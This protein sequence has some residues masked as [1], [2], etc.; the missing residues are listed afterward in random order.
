MLRHKEA[1]V[2]ARDVLHDQE[3]LA[4]IFSIIDGGDDAGV[5]ELRQQP[6]LALEAR[7]Q[8]F[9]VGKGREK[10]L[11]ATVRWSRTCVAR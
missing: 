7:S 10:E 11:H 3:R 6:R 8:H 9:M 5:A 2:T 1:K 4:R